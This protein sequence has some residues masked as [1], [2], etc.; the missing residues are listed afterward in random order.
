MQVTVR[1]YGIVVW[2]RSKIVGGCFKMPHEYQISLSSPPLRDCDSEE[3]GG[4]FHPRQ[5]FRTLDI[6]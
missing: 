4:G 1:T 6:V 3:S 2:V 5:C